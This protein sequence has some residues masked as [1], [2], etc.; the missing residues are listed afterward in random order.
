MVTLDRLSFKIESD[1]IENEWIE[2]RTI[3]YEACHRLRGSWKALRL[4]GNH[5]NLELERRNCRGLRTGNLQSEP[6]N[7]FDRSDPTAAPPHGAEPR[8]WV[9][10]GGGRSGELR[11]GRVD[12]SAGPDRLLPLRSGNPVS[13][14]SAPCFQRP[15]PN[16][17]RTLYLYSVRFY[18]KAHLSNRLPRQRG[19]R[20]PL[21]AF[22][23]R[24]KGRGKVEGSLF[25]RPHDRRWPILFATWLD[26]SGAAGCSIGHVVDRSGRRA[27][28][29]IAAQAASGFAPRRLPLE[30]VLGR[31]RGLGGRQG[32]MDIS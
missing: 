22:R 4:A 32:D 23:P 15:L 27:T 18:R 1:R 29:G 9:I 8:R 30:V 19:A 5:R 25:L 12:R 20:L 14:L 24:P 10:L 16:L 28:S 7:P 6:R 13:G 31:C 3:D 2:A 26:S 17:L 21:F 11:W